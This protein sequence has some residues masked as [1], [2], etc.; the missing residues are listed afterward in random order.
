MKN[1]LNRRPLTAKKCLYLQKY[2]HKFEYSNFV[3]DKQID[4]EKGGKISLTIKN[5]GEVAG[6]DVIQIYIGKKDSIYL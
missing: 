6:S 2:Y 1:I 3:V 4:I 5:I